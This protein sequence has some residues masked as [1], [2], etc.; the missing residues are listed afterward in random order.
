MS[1]MKIAVVLGTRPEIIKMAPLIDEI[2]NNDS[3][4]VLIHTGQHYDIEMS[5]QF[6][7]DLNLKDADY[8][9]DI[10]SNTPLKQ[11]SIIF[12]ELEEIL[13]KEKV[14]MVLVQGDTNTVQAGAICANK[15]KIPV[16]HVEAGLRSFDESMPEEIN[17]I[18]ADTCSQLYFVPTEETAINLQQEGIGHEDIY[19]TGNTIV[20]ACFRHKTIAQEKSKIKDE[21]K[22]DD[23]IA[24]TI[25]RA[26]NVDDAERLENIVDALV[27][28]DYNLIFPLHP[29]TKKSLM[30]FNLYDKIINSEHIQITKPLGYLDFLYLLSK[31]KL[32]LTDSGG[33]Q[34]EAIT[35]DIPCITLRY[36][37][38]RPET[39]TAGGNILAGTTSEEINKNIRRILDDEDVYN[40]MKNAKNPYGNGKTSKKIY[41]IIKNR[42]ADDNLNIRTANKIR[43]FIG[44]KLIKIEKD[45]DVSTYEENNEGQYI[46]AVYDGESPEYITDNLNL[47]DKSIVVKIF[48]Y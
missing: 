31:S 5:K 30:E 12:E 32:I 36:N 35:L 2:I 47:K 45:I 10:K 41:D 39:I 23:Y 1:R 46:T 38:E 8:Y 27:N 16:G 24:L 7:V 33:V 15:L 17:R 18:V 3:E 28:L 11:M 13:L 20:D 34:E 42:L 14:D 43:D 22:F 48:T 26:E 44:Y 37:T 19:V 29:H 40:Q 9:I 4:C 25:H 21:I 6:F